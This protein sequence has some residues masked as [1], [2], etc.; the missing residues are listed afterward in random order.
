MPFSKVSETCIIILLFIGCSVLSAEDTDSPS[1]LGV[2]LYEREKASPGYNLYNDHSENFYLIDMEG[3]IIRH[4]IHRSSGKFNYAALTPKGEL[5]ALGKNK[6][7]ILDWNSQEL[8]FQRTN[9]HHDIAFLENGSFL[10]LGQQKIKYKG[11][12]VRFDTLINVDLHGG[13]TEIWSS[14]NYL[15]QLQRFH[16]LTHHD[17]PDVAPYSRDQEN[18]YHCNSIQILPDTPLG[19]MDARFR[20]GNILLSARN[21]STLFILDRDTMKVLWGWGSDELDWQHDPVMR[22][23]GNI[24]IYDN[25]M[26][27]RFSRLVEM[28][29]VTGGV[30]W[31]YLAEP[32]ESFHNETMGGVQLLENGNILVTESNISRVFELTS[33]GEVV[34]DFLHPGFYSEDF[35]SIENRARTI[36]KMERYSVE[37]IERIESLQ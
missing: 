21:V 34:W 33:E 19:R 16:P 7:A 14:F 28:N 26:H 37:F 27:R 13:Q 31:E 22:G 4:W 5:I 29:P 32:P 2:R 30:V 12:F 20:A 1:P 8:F 35:K 10:T 18:Y 15:E 23:D 17:D 36:Y 3:T 25:G 6:L 24:L 9:L 11:N